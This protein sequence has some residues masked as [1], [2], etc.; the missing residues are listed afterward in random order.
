MS[1][2]TSAFVAATSAFSLAAF[3]LSSCR[4][5]A[6]ANSC[7]A[8]ATFASAFMIAASAARSAASHFSRALAV[9]AAAAAA[10]CFIFWLR[11]LSRLAVAVDTLSEAT[12]TPPRRGLPP[13]AFSAAAGA[14]AARGSSLISDLL[15][16]TFVGTHR[17][18]FRAASSKS[19]ELRLRKW[20]NQGWFLS[21]VISRFRTEFPPNFSISSLTA[22]E[23]TSKNS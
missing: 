22:R 19:A 16:A 7:S 2:A 8:A 4:E 1:F 11:A 3:S 20:R 5:R 6:T 14:A 9:P 13:E 15:Q 23:V 12:S 17:K 10:A 18:E 21:S